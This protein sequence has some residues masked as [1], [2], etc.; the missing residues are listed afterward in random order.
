MFLG[1]THHETFVC[2]TELQTKVSSCVPGFILLYEV[3]AFQSATAST[4]WVLAIL[5]GIGSIS[6]NFFIDDSGQMVINI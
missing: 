5:S 4:D 2:N 6:S 3:L 1:R